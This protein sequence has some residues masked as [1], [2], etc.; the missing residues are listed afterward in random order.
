MNISIHR[1]KKI[2]Q[3]NNPIEREDG[4]VFFVKTLRVEDNNTWYEI[5]LVSDDKENLEIKCTQ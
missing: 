3:H 5:T 4:T 2:T 1:V